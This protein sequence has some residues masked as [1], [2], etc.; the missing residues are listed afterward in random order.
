V[1]VFPGNNPGTAPFRSYSP[2]PHSGMDTD[3]DAQVAPDSI[4][5]R[6]RTALT[7]GVISLVF[8]V[9]TGVPAIWFGRKALLQISAANGT[10]KGR[11]AAWTGIGLGCLGV[12]L[13]IGV[14]AYLH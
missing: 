6:A 3:P 1:S 2:G 9:L 13:T 4:D 5:S 11:W 8:G 12:A 10:V 14:W 7:L